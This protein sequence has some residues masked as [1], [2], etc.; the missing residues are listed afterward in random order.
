MAPID[1]A[2]VNSRQEQFWRP[3]TRVNN[4]RL[5]SA[6]MAYGHEHRCTWVETEKINSTLEEWVAAGWELI[7][8][9]CVSSS[10]VTHYLYF[11]REV[12]GRVG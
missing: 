10:P 1:A 11:R 7:T 8:A 4:L 12:G 5:M 2:R 9:Y 3:Y 6:L